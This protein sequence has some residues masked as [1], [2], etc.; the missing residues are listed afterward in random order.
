MPFV[1]IKYSSKLLLKSTPS[2]KSK[3]I[4]KIY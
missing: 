3:L 2:P 1:N 4:N